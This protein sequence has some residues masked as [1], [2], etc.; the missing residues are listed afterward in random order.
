MK[1]NFEKFNE[2]VAS[3]YS[4]L[5]KRFFEVKEKAIDLEFAEIDFFRVVNLE[6]SD[7]QKDTFAWNF[8]NDIEDNKKKD[9]YYN[10]AFEFD[11]LSESEINKFGTIKGYRKYFDERNALQLNNKSENKKSLIVWNEKKGQ[12][13]VYANFLKL[14]YGIIYSEKYFLVEDHKKEEAVEQLAHFFG[15]KMGKGWN[16]T[17][18]TVKEKIGAADI[19]TELRTSYIN[20][21]KPKQKSKVDKR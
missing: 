18:Y 4:S 5:N 9:K 1:N 10:E 16:T 6:Y 21:K 11:K 13:S 19:F 7:L 12:K 8:F 20:N 3:V 14:A 2:K 17:T 15:V